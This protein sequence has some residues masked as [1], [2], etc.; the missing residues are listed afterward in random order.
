[1]W[2]GSGQSTAS[3]LGFWN[4][5]RVSALGWPYPFSSRPWEDKNF[6]ECASEA[7]SFVYMSAI[8][9]SVR[10]SG[11]DHENSPPSSRWTTCWFGPPDPGTSYDLITI[12]APNSMVKV[13]TGTAVI[14]RL[15]VAGQMTESSVQ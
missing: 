5:A 11:A 9:T 6:R 8:V 12:R 4:P 1:M 10:E 15:S 2:I 3:V 7:P 13:P 14:E